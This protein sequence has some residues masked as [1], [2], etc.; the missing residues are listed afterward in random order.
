MVMNRIIWI[1]CCKNDVECVNID[2]RLLREGDDI[3]ER[4]AKASCCSRVF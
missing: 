4:G 1:F 2:T 3:V